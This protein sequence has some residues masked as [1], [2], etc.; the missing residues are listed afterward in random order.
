VWWILKSLPRSSFHLTPTLLLV[1][2]HQTRYSRDAGVA[3]TPAGQAAHVARMLEEF[4]FRHPKLRW[5][6]IYLMG[7]SFGAHFVPTLAKRI[8][9]NSTCFRSLT[10]C[11]CC[12]PLTG[13][14][15]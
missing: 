15:S 4:L 5:S 1:P 13:C 10:H 12:A 11:C 6:R 8:M 3:E 14:I 7:T 9:M 2:L